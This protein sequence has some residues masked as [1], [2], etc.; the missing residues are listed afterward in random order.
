MN[1]SNKVLIEK[2]AII[3]LLA[4]LSIS[5]IY[6]MKK[7]G[8]AAESS[9][10]HQAVPRMS[11][12]KDLKGGF[13]DIKKVKI[14]SAPETR[15]PLQRPSEI[16]SIDGELLP[17]KDAVIQSIGELKAEFI[18]EGII[19]GGERNLAIV[20]GSVVSEGELVG[21]AKVL[22]ISEAGVTLIKNNSKIEL[23]R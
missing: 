20:S 6:T 13:V 12:I 21:D 17:S 16:A 8:G 4:I 11:D 15:D 22:R 3:I 23:T 2:R 7:M 14:Q 18:L 5:I 1:E 10:Q 19:W 9:G